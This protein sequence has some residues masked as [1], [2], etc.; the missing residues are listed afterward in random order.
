MLIS[1]VNFF[2]LAFFCFIFSFTQDNSEPSALLLKKAF[3]KKVNSATVAGLGNKFALS[4]V[5]SFSP[6]SS[7]SELLPNTNREIPKKLPIGTE[8]KTSAKDQTSFFSWFPLKGIFSHI[9]SP[10]FLYSLIYRTRYLGTGILVFPF[11]SN[12]PAFDLFSFQNTSLSAKSKSFFPSSPEKLFTE[13]EY[14]PCLITQEKNNEKESPCPKESD[15]EEEELIIEIL[16]GNDQEALAY[17]LEKG[18]DQDVVIEYDGT[19][20]TILEFAC[21]KNLLDIGK[22]LLEYGAS[23]S[24]ELIRQVMMKPTTEWL[25]LLLKFGLDP[26]KP[27]PWKDD[28][29]QTPLLE[30]AYLLPTEEFACS[31]LEYKAD[32]TQRFL[33]ML[34]D[35]DDQPLFKKLYEKNTFSE[36]SATKYLIEKS[37]QMRASK[38]SAYLQGQISH[39]QELVDYF[40]KVLHQ[41]E[42]HQKNETY[43]YEAEKEEPEII[44]HDTGSQTDDFFEAT[45]ENL[46]AFFKKAALIKRVN[47]EL[48]ESLAPCPSCVFLEACKNGDIKLIRIALEEG[49]SIHATCRCGKYQSALQVAIQ[50]NQDAVLHELLCDIHSPDETPSSHTKKR[51]RPRIIPI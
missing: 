14:D 12:M 10:P 35:K 28:H 31:L 33:F 34:L 1:K 5:P 46:R 17:L 37:I 50:N 44:T 32:L 24:D 4:S 18:M 26:N 20:Y 6:K 7:T 9:S 49:F 51:K 36:K 16:E 3:P 29:N 48:T 8:V 11:K 45:E 22:L 41:R 2:R 40:E 43:E 27:Y 15:K 30:F 23:I 19:L 21:Q 47:G 38:I 13:S 39:D 25:C 42:H